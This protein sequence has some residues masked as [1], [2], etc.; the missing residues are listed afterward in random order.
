MLVYKIPTDEGTLG[1]AVVLFSL[2][3][4]CAI[5]QRYLAYNRYA[6]TRTK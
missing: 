1:I 6:E 2:K 4:E 3:A 5:E